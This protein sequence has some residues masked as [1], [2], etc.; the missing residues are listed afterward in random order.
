MGLSIFLFKWGGQSFLSPRFGKAEVVTNGN[1]Y[2]NK[3]ATCDLKISSSVTALTVSVTRPS[4]RGHTKLVNNLA[5]HAGIYGV[6]IGSIEGRK[7]TEIRVVSGEN[8]RKRKWYNNKNLLIEHMRRNWNLRR[9]S[10]SWNTLERNRWKMC[11]C[12]CLAMWGECPSSWS[13]NFTEH[14]KIGCVFGD[15]SKVKLMNPVPLKSQSSLW[16]N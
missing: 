6:T 3:N 2:V 14:R 16:K 1:L 13:Q 7:K 15:S 12:K 9:R 11:M 10:W 8:W 4:R 5:L